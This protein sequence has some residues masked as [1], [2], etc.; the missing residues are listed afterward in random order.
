VATVDR[1]GGA[2]GGHAIVRGI[3]EEEEGREVRGRVGHVAF[4][5]P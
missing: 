5:G 4:P 1:G 3:S 2:G